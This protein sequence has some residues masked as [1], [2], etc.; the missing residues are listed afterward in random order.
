VDPATAAWAAAVNI[1][2]DLVNFRVVPPIG[3]PPNVLHPPPGLISPGEYVYGVFPHGI[4]FER[5]TALPL[6][7]TGSGP[8]FVLGTPAFVTGFMLG[9][10]A[11]RGRR[12]RAAYAAAAHAAPQ[13]RCVRM[14]NLVLTSRNTLCAVHEP[15]GLR[16]IV[17][18]HDS[19][20][21][22]QLTGPTL[23]M[24]FADV[25]P[26]RL[27]GDWVPWCA[28]VVAHFRYGPA[29]DAVLPQL[30]HAVPAH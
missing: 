26:L 30:Q 21:S 8:R 18:P 14:I 11:Q 6:V 3:L 28:A 27:T 7:N 12:R 13:W 9:E 1:H 22:M 19:I 4:V 17:V 15:A 20:T 10:S 24:G 5:Y 29:A 23:T 2:A 25:E 16:W